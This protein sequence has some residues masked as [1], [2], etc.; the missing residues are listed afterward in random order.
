MEQCIHAAKQRT[1]WNKGKLVGQKAPL[2]LKD[3]WAIRVRLQIRQRARELALFNR[4]RRRL[5]R[6]VARHPQR[7]KGVLVITRPTDCERHERQVCELPSGSRKGTIFWRVWRLLDR[8]VTGKEV[9]QALR[10]VIAVTH[11]EDPVRL[12]GFGFAA[13]KESLFVR[14]ERGFNVTR[15]GGNG[16][17]EFRAVVRCEVGSFA[18]RRHQVRPIAKEWLRRPVVEFLRNA[19]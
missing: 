15:V 11:L 12:R 17:A 7:P 9:Q 13:G 14:E 8:L 10:R 18:R 6:V 3:I 4:V 1:P 19:G 2:K 16:L 5:L